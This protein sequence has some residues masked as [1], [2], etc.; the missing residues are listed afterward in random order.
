MV[1]PPCSPTDEGLVNCSVVTALPQRAPDGDAGVGI[2]RDAAAGG[3][4]EEVAVASGGVVLVDGDPGSAPFRRLASN[5]S[6]G[7]NS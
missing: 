3:G 1:A 5:A 4:R 2:G 6:S 7:T